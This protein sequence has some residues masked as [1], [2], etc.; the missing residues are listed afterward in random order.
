MLT[1]TDIEQ[2]FMAEKSAGLFFLIAG[3]AAISVSVAFFIFF[4]TNIY[5]GMAWPLVLLGLIQIIV[6]Y[7]I[8]TDS[9]HQRIDNVYAYDMNP[10]KLKSVE[11]PRME[12]AVKSITVF[13]W[14]E[15]IT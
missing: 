4:K 7:K 12:K 3:I 15:L 8:Y 13:L 1:K 6:G 5:K 14:I 11:L 10:A 2:Y 9:D